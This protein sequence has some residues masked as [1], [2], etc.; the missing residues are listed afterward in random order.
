MPVPLLIESIRARLPPQL[1]VRV[2]EV[3]QPYMGGITM[4]KFVNEKP[5]HAEQVKAKQ[6]KAEA[7]AAEGK[8]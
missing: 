2:P 3:L 4:M 7:R 1:G 8:A 6:A 5:K